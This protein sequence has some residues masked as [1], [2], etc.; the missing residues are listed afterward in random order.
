M[1]KKYKV[2][3]EKK[4]KETLLVRGERMDFHEVVAWREE[5]PE[6]NTEGVSH[7]RD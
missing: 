6:L 3:I 4:E 7:G 2:E 1:K 5:N